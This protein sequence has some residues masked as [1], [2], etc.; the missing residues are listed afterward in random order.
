MSVNCGREDSWEPLGLCGD[1]P[2]NS[3]GNQ[4][5][6]FIGMTDAEALIHWPPDVN[7]S[8]IGKDPDAG[9]DW[10]Q[11]KSGD[12]GWDTWMASPMQWTWT[13]ANSR[14]WWE[15]G[16]PCVL[17]SMGS[18]SVRHDLENEQQHIYSIF[19]M[20]LIPLFR[21]T[22]PPG[23]FYLLIGRP[24]LAFLIVDV[25]CWLILQ[26]LISEN[27]FISLS[28]CNCFVILMLN[29]RVT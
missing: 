24:T 4:T 10:N 27:I 28:F 6:I 7:C 2:I 19:P 8:F 11:R 22:F 29:S 14:R 18:Q 21:C 26:F 3:K 23:T 20:C 9:E 5:W 15:T 16:K 25:T 1:K 13:W 12:R 17:Q